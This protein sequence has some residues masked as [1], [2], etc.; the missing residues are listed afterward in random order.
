[1]KFTKIILSFA[2]LFLTGY[3]IAQTKPDSYAIVRVYEGS[4][5]YSDYTQIIIS[6]EDG[7]SETIKI[8]GYNRGS[9]SEKPNFAE[10]NGIIVKTL[11][12]MIDE[13]YKILGTGNLNY[14]DIQIT[15]YTMEK[16]K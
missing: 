13:G 7:K 11:N 8:P 6:Y 1:M 12:R 10:I 4:I 16:I 2:F 3:A 9:K 5:I 14:G 15:S